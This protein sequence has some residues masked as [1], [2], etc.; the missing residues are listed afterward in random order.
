MVFK[1]VPCF[2]LASCASG[3]LGRDSALCA[4]TCNGCLSSARWAG[5]W[6]VRQ[7]LPNPS[8]FLLPQIPNKPWVWQKGWNVNKRI[9]R[10]VFLP[11][12]VEQRNLSP[13]G[14]PYWAGGELRVLHIRVGSSVGWVTQNPALITGLLRDIWYDNW[15][16][17]LGML[18]LSGRPKT[19]VK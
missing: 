1:T 15:K 10:Q 7:Q 16:L 8:A 5:A 11:E 13:Q 18:L 4:W 9:W 19:E 6:S 2:F 17:Q 12:N 14:N 3:N